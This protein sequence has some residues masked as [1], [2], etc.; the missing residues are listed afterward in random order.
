MFVEK[1]DQSREFAPQLA[2]FAIVEFR[3]NSCLPRVALPR[4]SARKVIHGAAA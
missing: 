1:S 3:S 2:Y 4:G